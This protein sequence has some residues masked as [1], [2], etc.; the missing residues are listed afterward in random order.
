VI[1]IIII[2]IITTIGCLT[3]QSGLS[4]QFGVVINGK[5]S[6]SKKQRLLHILL[7][8]RIRVFGKKE[9]AFK[10][11][12]F[13]ANISTRISN[14]QIELTDEKRTL[15][16]IGENAENKNPPYPEATRLLIMRNPQ[17]GD[18]MIDYLK[19][20]KQIAQEIISGHTISRVSIQ[21]LDMPVVEQK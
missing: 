18:I 11:E 21:F 6:K 8:S 13:W 19:D 14:I 17:T 5:N 9:S 20:D 7:I 10:K 15:I 1:E 4:H 2:A 12:Y 16:H 3:C